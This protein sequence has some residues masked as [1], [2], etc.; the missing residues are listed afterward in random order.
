MAGNPRD[1]SVRAKLREILL[2]PENRGRS[3]RAVAGE[4]GCSK[5]F[6]Q[7]VRRELE[8]ENLWSPSELINRNMRTGSGRPT[9]TCTAA[10]RA[11]V[12]EWLTELGNGSMPA[13]IRCLAER[14]FALRT[15]HNVGETSSPGE[16]LN[17][18]ELGRF[19]GISRETARRL[20]FSGK[21]TYRKLSTRS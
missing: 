14:T 16:T 11:E 12:G 8:R 6:L 15:V 20:C 19:L 17:F 13:G 5:S 18:L 4:V 10:V 7:T 9:M 2:K 1:E 21:I 3:S